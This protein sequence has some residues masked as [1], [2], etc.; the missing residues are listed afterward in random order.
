MRHTP[1]ST[2]T[3]K[4]MT[5]HDEPPIEE[6]GHTSRF[7]ALRSP[8]T[9]R[10]VKLISIGLIIIGLLL[11][12]QA[13]PTGQ[14]MQALVGW[15]QQLGPLGPIIYIGVYAMA[16]VLMLPAWPLS[17][18]AGMIFGLWLGSL[19]VLVGATSGAAGAF[20]IGRYLA[21]RTVEKNLRHYPRFAA[22]DRAVGEGGWKIVALLRLSPAVP[23]NLQNYLYGLTAIRFWPCILATAVAMLPGIFLYVY[24]GFAGRATLEAGAVERGPGQWAL[25]IVGLVA[26]VAVTVY[27]TRLARRAIREQTPLEEVDPTEEER[28]A[29][30]TEQAVNNPWKGAAIAAGVAFIVL[31]GAACAQLQPQWFVNLVGGPPAVA[32]AEAYEPRPGGPGFDHAPFD[33]ILQQHVNDNG[34]VDYAAIAADPEPLRQYNASLAQAP[35]DAMGRDEKLALLINAY[36]SFTLELMIDWLDRPGINGIRDIPES[37]RWDAERWNIGGHVWSLNQIEHE[38]IRPK[39]REPDIHWALVCAAVGCPPL[40]AEAYTADRLDEQLRDQA[41]IAH[42]D[43][44]R[45]LRY[46]R[47][48]GVIHL[49]ALYNW[50]GS[51][52][53]QVAG[54]VL[55]YAAKYH[56]PLKADLEADRR[57]R[58]QWLDY[59]WALNNQENLP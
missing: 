30:N 56:A 24:L 41:R 23:F 8:A 27:V 20:L 16:T 9:A 50:Y 33:A 46:D 38:Q 42:T 21:R 39:F 36:N 49:T 4:N 7:A 13:L 58:V 59:D 25:M 40:H 26:T 53:E 18:A 19:V 3:T 43:G 52:F 15:V 54:S 45:W 31:F 10:W 1:A 34:G 29:M 2:G 44:S 14:W 57:P 35:F 12:A 47:E 6:P 48:R 51:D 11:I 32:M 37:Q 55:D 17:V 22:V 5:M 28:D